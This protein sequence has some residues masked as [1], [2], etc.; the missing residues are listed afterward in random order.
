MTANDTD[1]L[2]DRALEVMQSKRFFTPSYDLNKKIEVVQAILGATD[3]EFD[4]IKTCL[5]I[6]FS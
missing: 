2:W 3:E 5:F 6:M 4:K 1:S